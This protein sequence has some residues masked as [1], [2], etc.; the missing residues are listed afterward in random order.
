MRNL[1]QHNQCTGCG[2][3]VNA[4]PKACICMEA[5]TEGFL[6]PSID[7]TKCVQ[8]GLCEKACPVLGEER[9][10]ENIK[11]YAIHNQDADVVAQSSSGGVFTALAKQVMQ[12]GGVVYGAALQADLSVK[13]QRAET[14]A[15]VAAFRGSKYVQSDVGDVYKWAKQDLADGRKVLF[16]GTPC[17]VAAL[18]RYLGRDY[19]NLLSVDIICHSVP[20][21][22]VWQQFL[23]ELQKRENRKIT[24]VNFRDKRDGW[25]RYLFWARLEDGGEVL[26]K[27]ADNVYMRAFL[28]GL[29]TRS[30]C[31]GCKFKGVNRSSDLTLG[32]FWGVETVYPEAYHEAGTSLVLVNSTKGQA[33]LDMLA[34]ELMVQ[35]VD[36]SAALVQNEAYWKPS[37]PHRNREKFFAQLGQVE[38]DELVKKLLAP[39]LK[40]RMRQAWYKSLVRRALRKV[41]RMVLKKG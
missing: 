23:N 19:E 1:P 34:D 37:E 31:Y 39:T 40:E 3:C 4:C 30:S 13:H 10:T 6:Y 14:E 12:Q 33:A 20:S 15:A 22:K 18:R 38:M 25:Q 8:C 11:A 17:Q 24:K 7:V 36:M 41:Y 2:A 32:D 16:S 29:S 27:G 9:K 35:S 21:P 5:D 26:E 28:N